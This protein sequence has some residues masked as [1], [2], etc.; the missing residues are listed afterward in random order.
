M[1]DNQD[2][3]LDFSIEAVQ[4]IQDECNLIL[5]ESHPPSPASLVA[6][7]RPLVS[8]LGKQASQV[9]KYH[10]SSGP[11]N[12]PFKK[13]EKQLIQRRLD[14]LISIAYSKFYTFL[15]KDLPYCW[16]QL[17][18][19][20]SILKF[21]YLILQNYCRSRRS[22]KEGVTYDDSD[23]KEL[24]EILD[25]V[26]ILAG[27]AGEKR[28]RR[29]IN[30]AFELLHE[31][32]STGHS[33][34]TERETKRLKL[35]DGGG[36]VTS[37]Q[38]PSLDP[39]FSAHEPLTPPV[40]HAIKRTASMSME[41]FQL[42]MDNPTNPKRGPEPLILTQITEDW[43]AR[44]TNPWNKPSYLLSQTFHGRRLVP[45]EIGRSYVDQGWGQKLI[46][47]G[48]FLREYIDPSLSN[49]KY[50]ADK[51]VVYLAQHPLFSQISSLRNDVLIPELCYTSPP[52]NTDH[53]IDQPELDEPLLNAWFGPPGTITPL[54]TDPYHN[55]LI[56]V[57]G[58]KYVRLYSPLETERMQARGK[59]D[60]VEMGNTSMLDV[61]VLEGWDRIP[62]DSESEPSRQETEEQ[63]RKAFEGIPFVDCILE[64]G[65][66]L[67][68]PVGWWHYV[69]G[70]SVSFSV[71][72][73]W[74]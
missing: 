23:L 9:I 67:Y 69:R 4:D 27:G 47:F 72:F 64:S 21:C 39:C 48:E 57:V 41:S 55:L 28:G 34:D 10:E 42:Y 53:S 30:D 1:K 26:L 52:H 66:A 16:R 44:S 45:V 37:Q 19:D 14:D 65:D 32:W 11:S 70:L 43:P 24:V 40:K 54:H 38:E 59:E 56:Q 35:S 13:D 3:L 51:P 46:T 7:G 60:G 36:K 6:C 18:T 33:N 17:Y 5:S 58:R 61:G 8:L 31:S 20:A 68:I 74:N 63:A 12:T 2:S 25:R 62:Q 73:W 71:S 50:V 15:F 22:A 29:W 49:T